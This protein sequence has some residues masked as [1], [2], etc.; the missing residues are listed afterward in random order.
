MVILQRFHAKLDVRPRPHKVVESYQKGVF[1]LKT[2]QMFSVYTMLV[3]FAAVSRDV[4]QRFPK[5][6]LRDIQKND[7]KHYTLI[8]LDLCLR[9]TRSGKSRDYRDVI[10]ISAREVTFLPR[11]IMYRPFRNS[12]GNW[13]EFQILTIDK[14]TQPH[15][16]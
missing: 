12:A 4:T 10:V 13:G 3:S 15:E 8:I 5:E 16:R 2:H 9:K 11:K 1:N 14:M 7:D 6:A